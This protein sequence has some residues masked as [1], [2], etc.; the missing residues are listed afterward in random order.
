MSL[1]SKSMKE[2]L[3]LHNALAAKKANPKSFST[4]AKL[5]ARIE[6]LQAA[7]VATTPDAEASPSP[8]QT[9]AP[10]TTKDKDKEK[11]ETKPRGIGVGAL[12][13]ELIMRPEGYPYQ[14]IAEMVNGQ[15]KGAS[16]TP[17]SV[18]WYAAKMRKDGADVPERAK[19][20][21]AE[22]DAEQSKEWL[23]TVKVVKPAKAKKKKK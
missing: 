2:L 20:F 5:I 3:A 19:A 21:P 18:R 6:A 23:D 7:K 13:R 22:M 12:A 9:E 1:E 16:A 8:T 11:T 15:L 17:Q 10:K 14:L 4:K